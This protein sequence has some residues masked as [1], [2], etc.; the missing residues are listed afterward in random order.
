MWKNNNVIIKEFIVNQGRVQ[1]DSRLSPM[2]QIQWTPSQS[3][4]PLKS[5]DFSSQHH[6]MMPET[7]QLAQFTDFHPSVLCQ[8]SVNLHFFLF[9]VPST[10]S[11]SSIWLTCTWTLS[12]KGSQNCWR[13]M[14][15]EWNLSHAGLRSKPV[16]VLWFY[17][18][19]DWFPLVEQMRDPPSKS[20][21]V[22]NAERAVCDGMWWR[23]LTA[24]SFQC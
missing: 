10:Q 20:R 6:L 16:P 22:V 19:E 1:T 4:F 2:N 9:L 5:L 7:N 18:L 23:W 12:P 8:H 14:E 24:M 3:D 17:F 11:W 21:Q 15:Q 13:A